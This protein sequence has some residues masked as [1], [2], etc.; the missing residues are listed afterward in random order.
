MKV[1]FLFQKINCFPW[2][3]AQKGV[4]EASEWIE[5]TQDTTEFIQSISQSQARPMR[6]IE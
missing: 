2:K 4:Q 5:S 1:E 3:V 6:Y